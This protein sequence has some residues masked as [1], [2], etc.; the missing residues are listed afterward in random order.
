MA[1]LIVRTKTWMKIWYILKVLILI[2]GDFGDKV[3]T[4]TITFDLRL[5]SDRSIVD[6]HPYISLIFEADK[7][8][9]PR[10]FT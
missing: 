5:A 1:G 3:A 9:Q 2:L 10:N 4:I 6:Q 8:F 7:N